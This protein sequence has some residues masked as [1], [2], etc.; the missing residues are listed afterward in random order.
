M[1]AELTLV[2]GFWPRLQWSLGCV[3][4]LTTAWLRG[5][6]GHNLGQE[7]RLDVTLIAIYHFLFS[8]TLIGLI[9][10]QLPRITEP[11]KYAIPALIMCYAIS[12][13]PAIFGLGL[14]L[15]DEAAR[16]G[17]ILFTIVHMLLNF[18]FIHRGIAPHTELT[19]IRI[20]ADLLIILVLSGK[21]VR[22]RFEF[23]P[24]ALHLTKGSHFSSHH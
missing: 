13:L 22:C 23:S 14:I 5:N 19:F 8:A 6:C 17:T 7:R 24:V 21:A 20:A 4:A 12:V 9:T 11:W 3:M 2:K 10:W 16:V 1:L 18:E 15:R